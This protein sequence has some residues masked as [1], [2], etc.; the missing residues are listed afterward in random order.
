MLHTSST[1]P[2]GLVNHKK[3]WSWYKIDARNEKSVVKLVRMSISRPLTFKCVILELF[4][5]LKKCKR[6]VYWMARLP[7]Q[8]PFSI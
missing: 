2:G 7:I 5:S 3:K 6:I 1:G 4:E 8:Q